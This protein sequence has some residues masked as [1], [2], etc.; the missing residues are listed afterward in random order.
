MGDKQENRPLRDRLLAGRAAPL[1][2]PVSKQYFAALR[3]RCAEA[4]NRAPERAEQGG[5]QESH[6]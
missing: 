1:T 6:E 4:S 3:L 5:A 2:S